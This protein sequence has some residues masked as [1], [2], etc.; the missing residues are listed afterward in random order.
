MEV[1]QVYK[2]KYKYIFFCMGLF[3]LLVKGITLFAGAGGWSGGWGGG[4]ER[5]AGAGGWS[6]LLFFHY[7]SNRLC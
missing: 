4:L 3:N 7:M 2:K 5:G 6:G 1:K